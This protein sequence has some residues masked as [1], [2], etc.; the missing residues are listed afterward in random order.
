LSSN[1]YER[2]DVRQ[3]T[4]APLRRNKALLLAGSL[5][6][7]WPATEPAAKRT[8]K[9]RAPFSAIDYRKCSVC[10]ALFIGRP[11][12][13]GHRKTCSSPCAAEHKRRI[14]NARKRNREH[15]E[16]SAYSDITS[17][18]EMAM[19]RKAR[20][21]PMPGCGVRLT[22]KPGLPNSKH[23]DHIIPLGVGGT[24]S[25][26]NTRII[27]RSCNVRRPKDGSDY[28]GPVTLWAMLPGT[29]ARPHGGTNK[30]TC[31]KGLHPWVPENI[32]VTAGKKRCR[33]CDE[34]RAHTRYPLRPCAGCGT[35]TALQGSQAMCPACTDTAARQ[36]A[37][38]HA[39]GGL[40]WKQVAAM[41]GYGSGEGARYAAKRIGYAPA[42]RPVTDRRPKCPDCGHLTAARGRQ[43][44]ACIEARARRAVHLRTVNGWTLRQIAAEFGYTSITTVTNLM[45]TV[46]PIASQMGRPRKTA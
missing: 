24:H 45:K 17:E 19:R 38:L 1:L 39:A 27:C 29:V 43:C 14:G 13:G 16:R 25:H 12:D 33:A 31:R 6:S 42:P 30:T 20:K 22:D 23:L 10:S 40:S 35:P 44:P 3:S 11:S 36:A 37:E 18:Q 21:C 9:R 28:F 46:T 8:Y 41:V 4:V 2:S 34:V 26:G 15:L 5:A 32:I 7:A